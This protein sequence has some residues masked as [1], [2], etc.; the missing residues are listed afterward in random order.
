MTCNGQVIYR[1]REII[2]H[3]GMEKYKNN[4]ELSK[5]NI[6]YLRKLFQKLWAIYMKLFIMGGLF[7]IMF[8]SK[9][10]MSD[11]ISSFLVFFN[12]HIT[13]WVF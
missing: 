1:V 13:Y 9:F 6:H 10:K 11:C 3:C 4:M 5:P 8:K 7:Q 12:S 2:T